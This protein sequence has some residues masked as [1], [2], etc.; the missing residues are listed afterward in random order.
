MVKLCDAP[1]AIALAQALALK[2]TVVVVLV[3]SVHPAGATV[4]AENVEP[5]LMR[6]RTC[7]NALAGVAA[8]LV[9]VTR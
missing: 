3:A 5:L 9:L 4:A 1:A 7:I 6:K 8:V 2:V